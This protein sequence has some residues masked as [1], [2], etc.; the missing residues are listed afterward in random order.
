HALE[1]YL[2]GW[3]ADYLDPQDF[4]STLFKSTSTINRSDYKNP[5]FDTLCTQADALTDPQQRAAL[6]GQAHQI[7]MD[8][9]PVVPIIFQK[10]IALV[11]TDVQGWRT[12]QLYVLPNA[13]TT[14]T[15]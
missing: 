9:M 15:P 4:L 8:D 5:K 6:Y 10:R 1:F 14:K 3:I 7:L 13:M 2:I 11:H 12:S